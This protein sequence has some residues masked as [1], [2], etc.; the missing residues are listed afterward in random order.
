MDK[1]DQKAQVAPSNKDTIVQSSYDLLSFMKAIVLDLIYV[2]REDNISVSNINKAVFGGDA[3]SRV[4][5]GILSCSSPYPVVALLRAWIQTNLA[6]RKL[7]Y[8]DGRVI[9]NFMIDFPEGIPV[10]T[11]T[12]DGEIMDYT[13]PL[14]VKQKTYR[15]GITGKV[16]VIEEGKVKSDRQLLQEALF[17]ETLLFI[18]HQLYVTC[19]DK[20]TAEQINKGVLAE[21]A[22]YQFYTLESGYRQQCSIPIEW[23][24]C[25]RGD[26]KKS[27]FS[28]DYPWKTTL[29]KGELRWN[30]YTSLF[31]K[32]VISFSKAQYKQNIAALQEVRL[33]FLTENLQQNEHF[34]RLTKLKKALY[35]TLPENDL[36][37]FEASGSQTAFL[38]AEITACETR[39]GLARGNENEAYFPLEFGLS[40]PL[41]TDDSGAF[42]GFD[43][44]IAD[45]S[46]KINHKM[47]SLKDWNMLLAGCKNAG[48]KVAV[49]LPEKWFSRVLY[50]PQRALVLNRFSIREIWKSNQIEGICLG[51]PLCPLQET[52]V[53]NETRESIYPTLMEYYQTYP[54]KPWELAY[55]V[56]ELRFML[57]AESCKSRV[58]DFCV[59]KEGKKIKKAKGTI[60]RVGAAELSAY[61]VIPSLDNYHLEEEGVLNPAESSVYLALKADKIF[62]SWTMRKYTPDTSLICLEFPSKEQALWGTAFFNHPF[63]Q[64]YF[65]LRLKVYK[66][67]SHKVLKEILKEMFFFLPEQ[68]KYTKISSQTFQLIRVLNSKPPLSEFEVLLNTLNKEIE[69]CFAEKGLFF[70]DK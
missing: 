31:E 23:G 22:F 61:V 9:S 12:R 20:N 54:E 59:L 47:P 30:E 25:L 68:E 34:R 29:V 37:G 44:V 27:C 21:L 64:K 53:K 5:F 24:N 69:N 18:Q 52:L 39:L 11:D 46:S 65:G 43:M 42:K 8:E 26:L 6:E 63:I 60:N 35:N 14:P 4:T 58:S 15:H 7:C 49:L 62:A 38:K 51:L 16:I 1:I 55:T 70:Q 2:K 28:S 41:L 13:P 40:F 33:R 3:S 32:S 67:K 66:E 10:I 50:Q 56:E 48:G 17:R 57:K 36:F 45:Y 19:P